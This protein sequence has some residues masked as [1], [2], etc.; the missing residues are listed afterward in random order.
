MEQVLEMKSRMQNTLSLRLSFP[1][2]FMFLGLY[3]KAA[4]AS[5]ET[6]LS[7]HYDT[8]KA[9]VDFAMV[10]FLPSVVAASCV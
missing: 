9:L 5:Q 10:Q 1:A 2:V 6:T 7:A 4:G 8:E 3:L